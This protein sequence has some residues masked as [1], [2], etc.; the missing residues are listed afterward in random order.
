[1]S[2]KIAKKTAPRTVTSLDVLGA[3]FYGEQT[4]DSM[5]R[6]LPLAE[7]ALPEIVARHFDLCVVSAAARRMVA[8]EAPDV[9]VAITRLDEQVANTKAQDALADVQWRNAEA[10]FAIGVLVG[11]RLAGGVR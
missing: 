5:Q 9:A 1:M 4:D 8:Q 2:K 7:A 11:L 3:L 10:G 6:L